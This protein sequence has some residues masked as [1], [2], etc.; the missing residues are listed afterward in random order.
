M[1]PEVIVGAIEH[2]SAQGQDGVQPLGVPAHARSLE[3]NGH[4]GF[5]RSLDA[6]T[7]DLLNSSVPLDP[8][9]SFDP[10]D[11]LDSSVPSDSFDPNLASVRT[12]NHHSPPARWFTGTPLC[13]LVFRQGPSLALQMRILPFSFFAYNFFRHPF[14]PCK[15]MERASPLHLFA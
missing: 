7:P 14:S 12:D 15:K 1:L 9:D 8:S 10:S 3:T 5:T 4:N 13:S 2:R 11:L 6:H